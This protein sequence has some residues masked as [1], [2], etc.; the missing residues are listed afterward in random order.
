MEG[1]R[2]KYLELGMDDYLSKPVTMDA[3]RSVLNKWLQNEREGD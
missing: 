2:E 1:D 3:L